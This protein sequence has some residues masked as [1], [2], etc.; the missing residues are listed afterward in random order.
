MTIIANQ[1]TIAIRNARLFNTITQQQR[2]LQLVL[3]SMSDVLLVLDEAGAIILTNRAALH[4]ASVNHESDLIGKRLQDIARTDAV[5]QPILVALE[6]V[7]PEREVWTFDARSEIGQ[8]DYRV[9]M[10]RWADAAMEQSGY[11]I[12]MHDITTLQDLYRFKT[13]CCA[14]P[15]TTS[16]V[17]CRSSRATPI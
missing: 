7:E 6:Q 4:L 11:V 17:R 9:V 16:A 10:S 5:F 2:Q 14:L 8:R 13:R 12:V 1:A 3:Q 15:R